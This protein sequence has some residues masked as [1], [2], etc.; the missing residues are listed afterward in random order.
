MTFISCIFHKGYY[1]FISYWL[2]ELIRSIAGL[3]LNKKKHDFLDNST[4]YFAFE[5]ELLKLIL[6]NISDLLA[7]F[8]VLYTKI[9][10]K[11]LKKKEKTKI[12]KKLTNLESSLIYNKL[13]HSNN[14]NHEV[15][16]ILLISILDFIARS[17]YFFSTLP[18]IKR[19]KL[20]QVDWMLS[21]DIIA[22]TLFSIMLLKIKVRKHHKLSIILCLLGFLLMFISDSINLKEIK[23]LKKII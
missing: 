15:L 6:L 19:L 18:K 10:M 17:V 21:I 23:T 2:I 14:N 7:G 4:D 3:T 9:I 20:R 1:Y 22:R 11:P 5:E 16:L 8:L 13:S 12:E